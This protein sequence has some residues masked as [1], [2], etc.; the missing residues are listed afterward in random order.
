[1]VTV[2]VVLVAS[3]IILVATWWQA[4][5]RMLRQTTNASMGRT[6]TFGALLPVYWLG[7]AALTLF[8]VPW[9]VGYLALVITSVRGG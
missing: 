9:V 5:V 2:S 6:L 4:N 3:L 7:L 8:V 1:M